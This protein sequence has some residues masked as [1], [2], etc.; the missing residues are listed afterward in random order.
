M[1]VAASPDDRRAIGGTYDRRVLLWD[2]P[3]A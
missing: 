1:S 2:L 3:S